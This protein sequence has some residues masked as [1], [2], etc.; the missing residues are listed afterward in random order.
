M[1]ESPDIQQLT[2]LIFVTAVQY[3]QNTVLL[4]GG[5]KNLEEHSK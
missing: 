1:G 2:P 3:C 4:T 5:N